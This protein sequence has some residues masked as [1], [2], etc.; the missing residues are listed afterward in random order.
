MKKNC[1]ED[2]VVIETFETLD[3]E[4]RIVPAP[5][6]DH[7]RVEFYVKSL[8]KSVLCE[9]KGDRFYNCRLSPDGYSLECAIPQ[10]VKGGLGLGL[11]R[12]RVTVVFDND[13]FP[14]SEQYVPVP[15]LVTLEDG[16][17]IELVDGP[18]DYGADDNPLW[19]RPIILIPGNGASGKA[20]LYTEQELTDEERSQARSNIGA[21]A[22]RVLVSSLYSIP[23]PYSGGKTGAA[24]AEYLGIS[25]EE[26]GALLSGSYDCIKFGNL[27]CTVL[28]SGFS[29]MRPLFFAGA[30]HIYYIE[31]SIMTLGHAASVEYFQLFKARG[32]LSECITNSTNDLLNYYLKSETY[33]RA[34][35]QALIAA[36]NQF[37]YEIYASRRDV[38]N[39]AGNV[40]Y[41][42]GPTGSGADKY[43]EYVYDST[44]QDPWVKIGDTSINLSNFYTKE[45][46][47]TALDGK[48]DK[49]PGKGLSTNDYDNTTKERVEALPYALHNLETAIE[50]K[51]AIPEG[52]IPKDDLDSGVQT[53]LDKADNA[54]RY[55]ASQSLTGAQKEQARRNIGVRFLDLGT[56][57]G[58]VSA[59]NDTWTQADFAQ[60]FCPIAALKQAIDGNYDYAISPGSRYVIAKSNAMQ[61]PGENSIRFTDG[62]TITTVT[63]TFDS[64]GNITGDITVVTKAI[65]NAG[66]QALSAAEKSQVRTNI[67]AGT[68]SKP[69]NGIP[70][71]DLEA[72]VIPALSTS[73]SADAA[74]DAKAS[75]PKS[76]Y[77]EVHPA[78]GRAQ[79]AGG[80]LPNVFYNLGTMSGNTTFAFA[81]ATDNT[82]ENEWMFQF[83]TPSTAPTITWPQ[84]IT[85]WAGGSAPT[86]NASKTYQ[87]S[88]VNGLGV[89]VEF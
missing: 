44:K 76:V 75:T 68:Y 12:H 15:E 13:V 48:V 35:V 22:N 30:G 33:T 4:R 79:P 36:I 47:D 11:L 27:I 70:K 25:E 85:G 58:S 23:N 43:E 46:M 53:S 38:T 60:N 41:L 32:D 2:F 55:D 80:M 3:D 73:V 57:L 1:R 61:A 14:A 19:P 56:P 39:P 37:H 34:E 72:G 88:V 86:I 77:S 7:V 64:S 52:G 54:V 78:V 69:A 84:A 45:E 16:S 20:V 67:G 87:V 66:A 29:G 42:I 71:T 62:E 40:L 82:I 51:Y 59:V 6:P 83:T 63:V 81:S 9:R 24:T 26:F 65:L 28:S 50:E 49:V 5:V 21:Q 31:M 18:G 10:F 8:F 74:S 89:I 17:H